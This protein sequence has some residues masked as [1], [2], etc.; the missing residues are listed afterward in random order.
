MFMSK[1]LN[2]VHVQAPYMYQFLITN[3][4]MWTNKDVLFDVLL[5]VVTYKNSYFTKHIKVEFYVKKS[6][7][8]FLNHCTF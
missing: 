6:P 4:T 5:E 3:K 1:T 2:S 8:K 7:A